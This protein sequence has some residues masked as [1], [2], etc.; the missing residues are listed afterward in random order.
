MEGL[1]NRRERG[2]ISRAGRNG[3]DELIGLARIARVDGALEPPT[4]GRDAGP[5]K[6]GRCRALEV[7]EGGLQGH[8][9]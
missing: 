9:L 8:A 2:R 5:F 7:G 3:D 4:L 1:G 6:H